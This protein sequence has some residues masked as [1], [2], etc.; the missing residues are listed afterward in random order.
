MKIAT[1]NVNSLKVRLPQVL[2]WVQKEQPDVLCLQEL[3]MPTELF[4]H[5]AFESLGYHCAVSGQKTYNG[6]A[7]LAKSPQSDLVM[8]FPKYED[9]Q[10]RIM[11]S[12]I[13]GVRILNIYVPNGQEVGSDKYH[14]K[15]EWLAQ[16]KDYI[17][18]SLT[19]YPKMIILGD[20][21]IAPAD[22][23]VYDPKKWAGQILCSEG[24][25]AALQSVLATGVEDAFRLMPQTPESYSWW[26]YRTLAYVGNRGLRIDLILVS[27]ALVPAV[28]QSWIDVAPRGLDRPSDHAP[29]VMVWA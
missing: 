28:Q 22:E 20:F 15:I 16:L 21:N 2:D 14:Y 8:D 6:V 5:E 27:E 3:K 26:D 9:A 29:V 1:W 24:E 25:R 18:K 4:P 7:T 11:A 23:D 13:A 19:V 12:T 17:A 10:R